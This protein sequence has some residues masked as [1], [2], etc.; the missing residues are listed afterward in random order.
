MEDALEHRANPSIKLTD[1][2]AQYRGLQLIDLARQCAIESG[3]NVKGLSQR[4]VAMEALGLSK[5]GYMSTSDFPNVLANVVNKTLRRQY[6][7]QNPTF[8]AFAQRGTFKDF[9]AK[10]IVQLGDVTK[11]KKILEGGEYKFG[12]MGETAETYAATKYGMIIP[13]T[14]ESIINDD[15]S[16]FSRIPTSIANKARQL[17]SD[18]VYSILSANAAMGDGVALFDAATHKNY[19]STGTAISVAA[20]QVARIAMRTQ[21]D[22]QGDALNLVPKYLVVGPAQE[23][24][25]YQYTSSMYTPTKNADINPIYNAALTVIVEPRITG[26]EW[27][28]VA[29][30]AMIDTIEY[31]FLEGEGELF[32]EQKIGFDVDG[33]QL[34]ARMVFNAKAIDYR[35]M[36]KNVGA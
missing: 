14:W 30:P 31:A 4:E 35:G 33:M 21:R 3:A 17:Q 10:S 26:T 16:A 23:Q 6:E 34:K 1:I 32:T 12:T 20:L 15:L 9:K 11:M 36:Y 24:L 18:I 8:Q 13:L 27:Y 22:V 5:R 7:L 28:L 29:D 2:G 25:A 19:T